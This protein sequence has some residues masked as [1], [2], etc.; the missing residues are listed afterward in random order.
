VVHQ[1]VNDSP[2]LLSSLPSPQ[3]DGVFPSS[4]IQIPSKHVDGSK[5]KELIHDSTSPND[6]PNPSTCVARTPNRLKGKKVQSYV[7]KIRETFSQVKVNI[8][9]LDVIQQMLPILTS[10]KTCATLRATNAPKR[11]FLAFNVSFIFSNQVPIKYKD[12]GCPIMSIVI[13]HHNIH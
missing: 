6:S 10:L 5:E 13:G 1:D 12:P 9:L 11:A 4:L 7:N 3:G 8:P 2:S